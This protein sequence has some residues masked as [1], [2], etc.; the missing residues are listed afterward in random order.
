MWVVSLEI[1]HECII[2]SKT[3]KFDLVDNTYLLSLY[4]K[5]NHVYYTN[6]HYLHG[7][8]RQVTNFISA[9]KKDPQII[10]VET[11]GNIV[12]TLT[13]AKKL[14][15]AYYFNKETFLITPVIHQKEKEV[16]NVG[17]WEKEELLNFI[18]KAKSLGKVK[19]KKICRTFVSELFVQKTLPKL[20]TKQ[21]EALELAIKEGYYT[22]P[23]KIE[24]DKL[25]QLMKLSRATYQEHLRKAE[26]KLLPFVLKAQL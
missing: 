8:P 17:A 5:N 15:I 4:H 1:E 9:L 16:W 20:T 18:K 2:L 7:D 24:T 10:K 22:I 26:A 21:R 13:K 12:Y 14:P 19:V 6:V 23:K 25:A 3:K 11:K